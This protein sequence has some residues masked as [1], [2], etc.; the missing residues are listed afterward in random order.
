MKAMLLLFI[1]YKAD[2]PLVVEPFEHLAQYGPQVFGRNV[3]I[4]A[5]P[6]LRDLDIAPV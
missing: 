5:A 6:E 2:I 1:L 4:R 3:F